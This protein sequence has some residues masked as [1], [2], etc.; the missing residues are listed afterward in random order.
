MESGVCWNIISLQKYRTKFRTHDL[1][2]F[3]YCFF[4]TE[5]SP[6]WHFLLISSITRIFHRQLK[7][8]TS[9]FSPVH[10]RTSEGQNN[11]NNTEPC[12]H[13][14]SWPL[15]MPTTP[16][17]QWKELSLRRRRS[18]TKNSL[19]WKSDHALRMR[20]RLSCIL[21]IAARF[22]V[23]LIHCLHTQRERCPPSFLPL[24]FPPSPLPSTLRVS[25][26]VGRRKDKAFGLA[27][28]ILTNDKREWDG[29]WLVSLWSVK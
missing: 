16:Q 17:R 7:T 23:V 18:V 21:Q 14:H 27:D 5:E 2:C 10:Q 3:L 24:S 26:V 11:G 8:F 13:L 1:Q 19:F 25:L 12:R 29:R 20:V 6:V 9:F 22:W 28:V 4:W 15:M